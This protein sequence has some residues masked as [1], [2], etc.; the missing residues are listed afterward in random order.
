[1]SLLELIPS[2]S[3]RGRTLDS[4]VHS[5]SAH[6]Q[7]KPNR[8]ASDHRSWNDLI[9]GRL[10]E[11]ERQP[12]LLDD[13]GVEPPSGDIIRLAIGLAQ[14]LRDRHVPPPER[15]VPDA[16]G[17]LAFEWLKGPVSESIEISDDGSVEYLRFEEGRLT[18]S[19][20]L[21]FPAMADAD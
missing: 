6:Q 13:E 20:A 8:S 9:D 12:E 2:I 14:F 15:V 19:E 10:A 7:V 3:A 4:S 21:L 17:G 16:N 11:W 5:R 1:M 18:T